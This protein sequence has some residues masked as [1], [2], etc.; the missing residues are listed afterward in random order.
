MI[1]VGIDAIHFHVPKL[2]LPIERLAE[3]RGIE[4]AKLNKGLG[5]EAMSVCDAQEDAATLAAEAAY[6]LFVEQGLRPQELDRIYLG[7]ESALDAAKPTAAY[8]LGILESKLESDFGP[9]SLRNCDVV[10]LTFA[11]IGGVDALLN[12]ADYVRL[13]PKRKAL[14]IAAD[15]AQYE[16][17]STGEYTQGAGAVAMLISA[18]PRLLRLDSEFGVATKSE[19]DFF[20]P[21][22][23][24]SKSSLLAEAAKLLG[25]DIKQDDLVALL[26]HS[27]DPFWGGSGNDI[28][29]FKEEPVFDGPY[30]NDC[31]KAR[32]AEAINHLQSQR[33]QL[34]ILKDWSYLVFHLPYAFQARRMFVEIWWDNLKE[35]ER[36]GIAQSL[37]IDSYDLS[38]L[39]SEDSRKI[40][41]SEPYR[42]FVQ[43]RI[44]AGERASSLIGNM[45]TA[46]IFMSLLSLLQD[47]KDKSA[48]VEGQQIGFIAYGS[49]S[50]S[51]IFSGTL[52]EEW[53]SAL[54]QTNLFESLS[55]R[56]TISFEEY[57]ALHRG[58]VSKNI[59]AG[60]GVS[61]S[62]ISTAKNQEG[63]R[64]YDEA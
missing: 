56:Q 62:A 63:Y 61:L 8:I 37:A 32:T 48:K 9:R 60:L 22:R 52:Q 33:P 53:V 64:F 46:S 7:T 39:S 44:Q 41:K 40:A 13:R 15:K 18:S 51:K 4:Y 38:T 45:Y 11:C 12:S 1:E 50:K 30:S 5:L 29:V 57:E 36:S 31:Y 23:K 3:A 49:G 34:N 21:R 35:D 24:Y 16:L 6:K 14:V 58:E 19:H 47:L 26:S 59:A 2:M 43:E 28:E 20:K 17:A 42:N 10:D 27:A 54:P 25:Q 55:Q